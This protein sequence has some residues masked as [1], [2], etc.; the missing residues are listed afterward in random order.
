MSLRVFAIQVVLSTVL[1]FTLYYDINFAVFPGE[2]LWNYK[3]FGGKFKFLTFIN[4]V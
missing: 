3:G 2:G 4:M 1:V